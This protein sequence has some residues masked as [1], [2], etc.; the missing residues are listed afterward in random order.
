MM[1]RLLL[2]LA[3]L[4]AATIIAGCTTEV[5]GKAVRSGPSTPGGVEVDLLNTGNYPIKPA[6]P[7]GAAGNPQV[8]ARLEGGRMASMVLG[9]WEIDPTMLLYSGYSGILK[10]SALGTF[11]FDDTTGDVAND[12]GFVTGFT[13]SR[14]TLDKKKA[15]QNVALRFPDP[16]AAQTAA[17]AI[18]ASFVTSD[19]G[20]T[21]VSVPVPNHPDTVAVVGKLKYREGQGANGIT[22][23]GAFVL[24]QDTEAESPEDAVALVGA[25]LDKQFPLV[26]KFVP[27]DVAALPDMPRDPTGLLAKT[28][29]TPD[30]DT[31]MNQRFVYDRRGGEQF[32]ANPPEMDPLYEKTG[33]D[34]VAINQ[35]VV[36]QARDAAAALV[37]LDGFAKA[38]GVG[39]HPSKVLGSVPYMPK[40]KCFQSANPS[41]T[42]L[43]DSFRCFAAADRYVYQA[44]AHQLLDV[45]QLTAA[46]YRMLMNL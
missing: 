16:A 17:R 35:T 46:Q 12:N 37:L 10:P 21:R 43:Q 22:A 27:T 41:T 25:A 8:G 30:K 4:M 33:M 1:K 5:D 38:E 6:A 36:Y 44:D 24:F 11:V 39:D 32:D 23:R 45:Q 40:T 20:K 9:P 18:A 28:V 29:P 42:K 31:S 26:D 34:L 19:Y 3:A 15:L 14:R 13:V 7:L 2:V